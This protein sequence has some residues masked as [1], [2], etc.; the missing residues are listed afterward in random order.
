V[1]H[2]QE[3]VENAIDV[4]H[5]G[6]VHHYTN[7]RVR[8]PIAIDGPRFTIGSAAQ[9]VFPLLGEVDVMLDIEA[10]GLGY[11]W[12]RA[13]I[14]RLRAE[15]LF[16]AMITPIDPTRVELR[17]SVGIRAGRAQRTPSARALLISRALTVGLAPAFWRDLQL[18]FPIWENK[19][20][21]ERPRLAKGDGPVPTYRRWAEQFYAG[22]AEPVAAGAEDA[23]RIATPSNT[24]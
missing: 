10:H 11:I 9:R 3:V 18:D 16:Q 4:G 2:P 8:R 20:Y 5:I 13:A 22:C 14:P 19:A 15:A 7:A 12:V 24:V 17:F 1:D 23:K 21:V 6:P